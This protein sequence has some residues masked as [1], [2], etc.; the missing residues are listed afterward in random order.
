MKIV[1]ITDTHLV[2]PGQ[3]L[4]QTDPYERLAQ[5]IDDVLA[6]HGDAA[7]CVLTGDLAHKGEA[8]AYVGLAKQLARLP[9]PVY[10]LLG[11]HDLRAPFRAAFPQALR[12]GVVREAGT[13][14]AVFRAP[15]DGYTR[16]LL[17]AATRGYGNLP[18]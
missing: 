1:H 11:N 13:T 10:P 16:M 8:A 14:E 6:N 15:A 18:P 12:D 2:T 9:M 17:D 4:Y 7:F 3:S 5:C